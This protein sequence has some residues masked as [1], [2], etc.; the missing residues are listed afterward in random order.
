MLAYQGSTCHQLYIDQIRKLA[1]TRVCWQELITARW[2]LKT[3]EDRKIRFNIFM[4]MSSFY[5]HDAFGSE[6]ATWLMDWD[7]LPQWCYHQNEAW[8]TWVANKTGEFRWKLSVRTSVWDSS[9]L[10]VGMRME[11]GP[12][13]VLRYFQMLP[14]GYSTVAWQNYHAWYFDR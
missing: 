3:L 10:Q 12:R 2:G 13:V 14:S 11:T 8:T 4:N 7:N 6:N 5:L 9:L 1:N